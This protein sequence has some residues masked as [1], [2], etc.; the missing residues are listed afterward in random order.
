M[1]CYEVHDLDSHMREV[2]AQ[3]VYQLNHRCQRLR[4]TAGALPGC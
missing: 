4:S 3:G 2:R 1:L